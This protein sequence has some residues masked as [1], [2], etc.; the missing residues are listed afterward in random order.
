MLY[1][2]LYTVHI[3]KTILFS[4]SEPENVE[5]NI[6]DNINIAHIRLELKDNGNNRECIV[7]CQ[8][9]NLGMNYIKKWK[10]FALGHFLPKDFRKNTRDKKNKTPYYVIRYRMNNVNMKALI[11]KLI[12]IEDSSVEETKKTELIEK[13]GDI[14]NN[15]VYYSIIKICP[16]TID[17]WNTDEGK[18][19]ADIMKDVTPGD[20]YLKHDIR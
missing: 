3:E 13:Y 7:V 5:Y 15:G 2:N 20:F 8:L 1:S 18:R 9:N 6:M 19:I 11:R 17:R 14:N 10:S 16:E 12:E 4:L